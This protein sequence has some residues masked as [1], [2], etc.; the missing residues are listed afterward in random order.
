MVISSGWSWGRV[1]DKQECTMHAIS[2]LVE[3]DWLNVNRLSSLH[4]HGHLFSLNTFF[5]KLIISELEHTT[6][7]P[8]LFCTASSTT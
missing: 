3:E 8:S 2:Y 5:A 7:T 4:N 6:P 1:G